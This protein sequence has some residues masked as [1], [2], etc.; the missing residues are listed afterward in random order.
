M[1]KEAN[2]VRR[3]QWRRIVNECINRDSQISKRRWCEENG[4]KFRSFTYWQHKSRKEALEQMD[5]PQTA[6]P[7]VTA[8]ASAPAFVDLTAK[9]EALQPARQAALRRQENIPASTELMIRVGDLQIYVNGSVQMSTLE[10]VMKVI[11][12]A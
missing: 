10:K 3:E 12:H 2:A 6:A 5:A 1:D 11:S 9:Y 7:A 4:I 8:P